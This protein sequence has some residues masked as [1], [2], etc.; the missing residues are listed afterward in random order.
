L[1]VFL[2]INSNNITEIEKKIIYFLNE[3]YQFLCI[4]KFLFF[5]KKKQGNFL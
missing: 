3:K 5:Y 1:E 2:N 4:F